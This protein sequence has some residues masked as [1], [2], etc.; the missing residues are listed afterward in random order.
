MASIGD[1]PT[2]GIDSSA[3]ASGAKAIDAA[4]PVATNNAA[5]VLAL[6]DITILSNGQAFWPSSQDLSPRLETPVVWQQLSWQ[7]DD[8]RAHR[9]TGSSAIRENLRAVKRLYCAACGYISTN[10]CH[11]RS[12]SAP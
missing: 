7:R 11:R 8:P 3:V 10:L 5:K 1:C 4:H 2:G 12:R 6:N 9:S